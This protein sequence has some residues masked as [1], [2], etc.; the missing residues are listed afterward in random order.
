MKRASLVGS[1]LVAIVSL[2]CSALSG[3][4]ATST[5]VPPPATATG[6]PP[7]ATPPLPSATPPPLAVTSQVTH[8]KLYCPSANE[9][10]VKA[11][12]LGLTAQEQGDLAGAQQ[13]YARAIELDPEYCD[14]MDNLGLL[15]RSQGDIDGAIA[16]YKKSIAVMP[17]DKVAH[18]NLGVAYRIVR[19]NA[20]A[21]QEYETLVRLDPNDPEGYFGLGTVYYDTEQPAQAITQLKKAEELY[22]QQGSPYAADARYYLGFSYFML[23]DCR[24]AR[25][26]LEPM[27]AAK[28]DDPGTNYV[29]GACYLTPALKDLALARKYLTRAQQLGMDIPPDMLK[30]IGQ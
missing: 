5:P 25:E 17:S 21:I 1:L 6:L 16:W 22:Q 3:S 9:A 24:S 27:Y 15:L 18:Q 8:E 23:K 20:E 26:Y 7:S 11:Y 13:A 14:A 29:L 30:M 10:A 19:M 28:E 4:L 2:A 12:N